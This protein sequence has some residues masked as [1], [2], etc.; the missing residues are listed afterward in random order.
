MPRKKTY[1]EP[2]K[3]GSQPVS[4]RTP[5]T[6][7]AE[8]TNTTADAGGDHTPSTSGGEDQAPKTKKKDLQV[9]RVRHDGHDRPASS[10]VAA[11]TEAEALQLAGDAMIANDLGHTHGRMEAR[12]VADQDSAAQFNPSNA[13]VI[14]FDNGKHA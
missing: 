6:K 10:I 9:W 3:S 7:Q 4:P 1:D 2:D 14:A 8:R 12:P 11:G 13:G 5:Q